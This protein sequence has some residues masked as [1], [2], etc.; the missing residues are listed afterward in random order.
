MR[1]RTLGQ[2]ASDAKTTFDACNALRQISVCASERLVP[3]GS[4]ACSS[5]GE[6]LTLGASNASASDASGAN[7]KVS[8]SY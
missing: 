5:V 7:S 3:A 4:V 8:K 2:T 1:R 6:H